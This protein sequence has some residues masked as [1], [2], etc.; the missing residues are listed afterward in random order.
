LGALAA[1]ASLMLGNASAENAAIREA[2]ARSVPLIERSSAIAIQERSNC[3]TCHHTGFPVMALLTAS[4]RGFQIDEANL[5]AQ[6]KFTAD[7]LARG[8]ANY[9]QG[10]GQGGQAVTAGTALWALKTG[11]WKPDANTEA[12]TGYL[13]GHQKELRHWKP[14]SIRP[15]SEE[16]PFSATF[17]ALEGLRQFRTGPQQERAETRTAQARE[18]LLQA[19]PQ[20]TEDRVFR[21]WALHSAGAETQAAAEELLASQR[22]DGG[23]AQLDGMESD[24]YATGT[25][26]VALQITRSLAADDPACQ[27][28][29]QW[30]L[31]AQLPDGSWRVATRSEPIQTYFESGYPHGKDQFI[32]ITAA[33][34]ATTALALSLPPEEPD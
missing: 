21:L 1:A 16:S 25:S 2:I 8:R 28:G 23:W 7:F 5:M 12:V 10:K 6:M 3:F 15:P 32:S 20:N 26:L 4:G 31:K 33:C 27:R 13:L 9:L 22:E 29:L 11:S 24:A 18:W 19:S 34:W 17:F 30:L 14:P